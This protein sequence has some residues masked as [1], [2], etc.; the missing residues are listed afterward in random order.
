M[1]VGDAEISGVHANFIVNHGA[2]TASDVLQL[3]D[4][5]RGRVRQRFDVDLRPEICRW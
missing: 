1:R 4:R 5:V 3:I 2:A